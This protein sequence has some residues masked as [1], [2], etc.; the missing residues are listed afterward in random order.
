MEVQNKM[1]KQQIELRNIDLKLVGSD[2]DELLFVSGYVNK[3]G[4]LSHELGKTTRFRERIEKGAFKQAIAE[5]TDIWFLAEHDPEKILASTET[6]S[7]VLREDE[8]GLYM[9]ATIS[10]TTWGRDYHQLIKDKLLRGM[11]FGMQVL[12]DKWNKTAD[13]IYERSI[14]KLRLF[15]ITATK[16]PAYPQSTISARSIEIVEDPKIQIERDY[17]FMNYESMT[18]LEARQEKQRLLKELKQIVSVEKTENRSL[19]ESEQID[20]SILENEIRSVDEAIANLEKQTK[21]LRN[22]E[23][24]MNQNLT[25]E[26]EIRAVEQFLR[27][28]QGEELRTMTANAG[29]GQLTVPTQVSDMIVEKLY[30]VAPL[31]ARTRNFTPVNGFLEVL[32]ENTIGNAGFVGE[33]TD[34]AKS[35][36]TMDKVR[37][38]QKRVGTAIELSQHL[39]NDSGIDVVGYST[40]ILAKRLGVTLDRNI[41]TGLKATEFEGLLPAVSILDAVVTAAGTA[42]TIDELLDLYNS[43][44]PSMVGEAVFVVSRATFNLISKLKDNNGHFHLVREVA[45]TGPVYRLFGQPVLISD[46]M[47]DPAL[48]QRAVLFGNFNEGYATM[49]KKGLQLQHISGDTTQAM[50]GSHLLLLD[51]YMDGKILNPEAFRFLKMKNA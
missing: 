11:S 7:L 12:K 4:E 34:L 25:Q 39:I 45:S 42:I 33:M 6:G 5:A 1:N 22:G 38:D 8:I 3:T 13:G 47:P 37:L 41:L 48:N 10:P 46:V 31:F 19:D 50:R 51:G 17:K 15:E 9:E 44:H 35:D 26:Q 27:K 28:E 40:K 14:S 49:T 43:M 21:T 16:Q 32:R 20:K 30:E 2:S 29:T 36:F 18:L 23:T 24:I